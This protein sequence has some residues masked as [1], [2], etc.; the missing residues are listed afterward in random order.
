MYIT[1]KEDDI[2]KA[3]QLYLSSQLDIQIE[4]EDIDIINDY[5]EPFSATVKYPK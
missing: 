4:V 2:K 5:D 1:F 3:I